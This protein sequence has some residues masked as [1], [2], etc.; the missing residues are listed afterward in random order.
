MPVLNPSTVQD[1]LDLGLL[2]FAMSRFSGCWV[3]F[4]CVTDTVESAA[5]VE[6]GEERAVPV[7]P[8]D[9][10]IPDSS[11]RGAPV[12]SEEALYHARLPAVQAFARANAM[13]R[14]VIRPERARIGIVT[15]GKAYLDVRQALD[16]LG[17]DERSCL[18]KRWKLAQ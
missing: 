6:V 12:G 3:G 17:L 4:K 15:T 9:F 5:S 11:R 8:G 13:D 1:Y 14:V 2:G 16:E 18:R 7:L 10:E